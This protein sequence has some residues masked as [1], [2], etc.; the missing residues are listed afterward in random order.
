VVH[1]DGGD[2]LSATEE[3]PGLGAKPIDDFSAVEK[4]TMRVKQ[5]RA[6]VK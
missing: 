5:G 4:I 6:E 1:H 3:F 2:D